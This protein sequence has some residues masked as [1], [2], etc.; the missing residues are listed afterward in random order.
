ML[1]IMDAY[2]F[3]FSPPYEVSEDQE[4]LPA[5]LALAGYEP[6]MDAALTQETVIEQL[7]KEGSAIASLPENTILRLKDVYKNSI[8]L[9]KE[10]QAGKYGGN[11]VFFRS[12]IVPDWIPITDAEAWA[13]YVAGSIMSHD[14]ESRHKDMCRPE[15]LSQIGSALCGLLAAKK[16]DEQ[17]A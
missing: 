7:G 14:I 9:L 3:H 2:P 4:A 6:E 10:H 12:T 1:A 17:Y 15:P 16:E 8:R 5:L 13:P 11:M